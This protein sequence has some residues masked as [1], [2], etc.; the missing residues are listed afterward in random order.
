M[1]KLLCLR[2]SGLFPSPLWG[3]VGMRGTPLLGSLALTPPIP[4][5]PHEE[6]EEVWPASSYT[7]S[8]PIT[9]ANIKPSV[10]TPSR[11]IAG[12]PTIRFMGPLLLIRAGVQEQSARR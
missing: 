5:L 10:I 4:A 3:R 2:A 1:R 11:N 7:L 9:K 6:R 8:Q 12:S